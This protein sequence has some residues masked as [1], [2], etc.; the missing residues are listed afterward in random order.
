MFGLFPRKGT[1]APGAD[2]DILIFDPKRK[3]TISVKNQHMRV[4]Y[5]AYE[6]LEVT[7]KVEKVLSRGRVIIDGDKY[8][9]KPGDGGF[10][11]R[12]VSQYGR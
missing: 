4:D 10:L 9:G 6:G 2:A 11:K 8:L 7:G 3:H 12:G 5:S 1:I